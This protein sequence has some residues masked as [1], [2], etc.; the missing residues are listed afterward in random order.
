MQSYCSQFRASS[1]IGSSTGVFI[2][3]RWHML[4]SFSKC[5][6][7]WP[8]PEPEP[9]FPIWDK[10]PIVG[11]PPSHWDNPEMWDYTRKFG[12]VGYF[13][14][15]KRYS[16]FRFWFVPVAWLHHIFPESMDKSISMT[17]TILWCRWEELDQPP[18]GS[19]H[20]WNVSLS[21]HQ[22]ILFT[23]REGRVLT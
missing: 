22:R 20:P 18:P 19:L 2:W 13:T 8:I 17:P 6:K 23:G 12:T 11:T 5:N 4:G 14:S 10:N 7:I 15:M 21:L 9:I 1:W 3:C 16:K